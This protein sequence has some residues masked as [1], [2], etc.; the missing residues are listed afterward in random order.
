M[1][2]GEYTEAH[3]DQSYQN[4]LSFLLQTNSFLFLGFGMNDPQDL[5]S[6]LRDNATAFRDASTRHFA[7][8]KDP[9]PDTMDRLLRE[10]NVRVIPYVDHAQVLPF[11]V[12]LAGTPT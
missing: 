5:D 2:K 12:S 9:Q 11:L 7:L 4:V 3:K 10:Y 8:I 1:T 6:V